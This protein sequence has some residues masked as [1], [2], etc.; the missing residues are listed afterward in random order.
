MPVS[1]KKSRG[2]AGAAL[3]PDAEP[4]F[5]A[6]GSKKITSM[7][8]KSTKRGRDEDVEEY[9][10]NGGGDGGFGGNG[11]GASGSSAGNGAI[12]NGNTGN[13]DENAAKRLKLDGDAGAGIQK[14]KI[15]KY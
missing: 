7:K 2:G 14:I 13:G 12:G 15:L 3:E 8:K 4:T 1:M 6:A 10:Q 9:I 11:S 5:G